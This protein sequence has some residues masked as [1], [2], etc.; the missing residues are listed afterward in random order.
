MFRSFRHYYHKLKPALWI[1]RPVTTISLGLQDAEVISRCISTN[2][3]GLSRRNRTFAISPQTTHDTISLHSDIVAGY[4]SDY[5][6]TL[7]LHYGRL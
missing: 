6:P 1:Y 4:A 7:Q 3:I 5:S 2:L